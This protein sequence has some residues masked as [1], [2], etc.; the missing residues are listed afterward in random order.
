[1]CP[2]N[3]G[4]AICDL[5]QCVVHHDYYKQNYP[6]FSHTYNIDSCHPPT[7]QIP[8][9]HDGIELNI[10]ADFALAVG[11]SGNQ[12]VPVFLS[13]IDKKIRNFYSKK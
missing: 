7:S 10:F 13:S 11:H 5:R 3:C 6:V 12:D 4:F 8:P 9:S 1:M 2:K